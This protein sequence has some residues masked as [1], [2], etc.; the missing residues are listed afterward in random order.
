MLYPQENDVRNLK[1][2]DGL[3]NF[4][5]DFKDEGF[6]NEWYK[7]KLD[8]KDLMPISSSYNDISVDSNIRDHIGNV[9]YEKEIFIPKMW[10]NEKIFIRV[11]SAS[12]L[13]IIWI[14]GKKVTEHQGGFLP[15]ECEITNEINLGTQ[16][17]IT[18]CVNN[19]L[20]W[21]T[22]PP[23]NVKL[24]K[25]Y[26]GKMKKE[27][28]YQHDFFNYSGIHRPVYIY[29][30]SKT[31]IKDITINT[32]FENKTGYIDYDLEVINLKEK[33]IIKIEILDEENNVVARSEGIKNKIKIENVILWKPLN[34]YLYKMNITILNEGIEVLDSYSI[35]IGIR[36]IKIEGDKF[37]IN[38][39]PFYFKGFGKHE[40]MDIK[41]K[42]LDL[43]TSMRDFHLLNWIN[44]NSFR[45]SHYPYAEEIYDLADRFGIVVIDE[46]PAVGMLGQAV[47]AMGELDGVFT[48]DKINE[49]T[50]EVHINTVKEMIKRDKNHPCVVMWSLANEASTT[51]PNAE[52]YFK[53]LVEETRKLDSRPLMN[54]NIMLTEPGK[55]KVSKYFDIVGLNLY[56]GWYSEVGDIE[57]GAARLEKWLEEWYKSEKKPIIMTEYGVDTIAGLHKL[58]EIMFTEEYQKVFLEKYHEVYDKLSFVIGE[59]VWNFADFATKQ[60]IVRVD[61]NKKG[62][63]TRQRQ[64]KSAAFL[65]KERWKK[66]IKY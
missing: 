11:G 66:I 59:H 38:N 19:E 37:L 52:S 13:G 14:N 43:A 9:W 25:S 2:I 27:L 41:G 45:T 63:F 65:L 42:G 51:E 46:V 7:K 3:W 22:L 34:S 61:G 10:E 62:I 36:T 48:K 31:Y 55:C 30:T 29:T 44:A 64:P 17:R 32:D 35:N 50:L 39:E 53:K 54:V 57:E 47:P 60:G 6:K 26:T 58:P 18:I 20:S 21:Q 1:K 16:N 4:K 15:F 8:T 40:D 33:D 5:V 24:K 12:H 23:G 28:T 56:F 49:K